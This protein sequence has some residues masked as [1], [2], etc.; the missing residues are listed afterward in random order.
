MVALQTTAFHD[1]S[2]WLTRACLAF[3]VGVVAGP[4]P[5]AAMTSALTRTRLAA[6]GT[7]SA[8]VQA[9]ASWGSNPGDQ[10]A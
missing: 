4:R 7:T 8:P 10:L 5:A 9:R 3:F 6:T 2:G 1:E